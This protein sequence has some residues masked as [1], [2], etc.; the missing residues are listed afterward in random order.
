[1]THD[2]L[3]FGSFLT[4]YQHLNELVIPFFIFPLVD[5]APKNENRLLDFLYDV[6]CLQGNTSKTKMKN[7]NNINKKTI[8]YIF[9]FCNFCQ[10]KQKTKNG[11]KSSKFTNWFLL[12]MLI[13]D[14]KSC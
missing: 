8:N 1:M 9:V 3:D 10:P 2:K 6:F 11:M 4:K 5:K 14:Q 7:N 12:S 13:F